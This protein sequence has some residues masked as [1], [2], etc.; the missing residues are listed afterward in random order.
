MKFNVMAS[1]LH[2]QQTSPKHYQVYRDVSRAE[3]VIAGIERTY[4]MTENVFK[5]DYPSGLC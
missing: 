1:I 4:D 3:H 2:V 5:M